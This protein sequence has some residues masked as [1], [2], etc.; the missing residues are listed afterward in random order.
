M[1]KYQKSD[2]L[3]AMEYCVR[4]LKLDPDNERLKTNLKFYYES[5]VGTKEHE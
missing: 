5:Y 2:P 1:A 3:T 4:A